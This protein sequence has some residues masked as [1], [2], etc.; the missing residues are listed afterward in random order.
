MK[1]VNTTGAREIL[2]SLVDGVDP[3]TGKELPKDSLF[4]EVKLIRALIFAVNVLERD[5]L[6]VA[7]R[8]SLPKNVGRPWEPSEET[9]LVKAFKSGVSTA[10]IALQHGRTA[11]AIEHRLVL[12]GLMSEG[13]AG[14]FAA[15][16]QGKSIQNARRRRIKSS[17]N[18]AK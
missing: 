5:E 8:S 13:T 16:V 17:P 1:S 10:E 7:R 4:N 11:R 9:Q 2:Q 12:L 15:I 14:T 18:K 3:F 6:K